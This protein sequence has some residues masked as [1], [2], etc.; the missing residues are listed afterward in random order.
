MDTNT[1]KPSIAVIM[2]TYN[3]EKYLREQ[4][5]SILNQ[6]DVNLDLYVRDDGSVDGTEEILNQY[7][8]RYPQVHVDL[9]ANAGV[10]NS[11]MNCL[12]SVPG[13]YQYY[14][15]A[16]QD[17]IWLQDKCIAGISALK[18]TGKALYSSNQECVDSDGKSRGLRYTRNDHIHLTTMGIVFRNTIAGCTFIFTNELAEK[19]RSNPFSSELLRVRI[20]DV[21][22]AA[23]ASMN[24]GIFYD[25][26]SHMEY[27]QHQ[28]NV[29]GV[30]EDTLKSDLRTKLS[31]AVNSEQRNGRSR[32]ASELVKLYPEQAQNDQLLM[33]CAD[34]KSISNRIRLI[35]RYGEVSGFTGERFSGFAGKVLFG[36]F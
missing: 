28:D 18:R 25:Q 11:F 17:D 33:L 3:G 32:L 9:A 24:G 31:K 14:G 34:Q 21:C 26:E 19:L 2:S 10:G 36:L 7:S 27:R 12:Y 29:V 16:D 23:A 13:E 6:K 5:D 35:R 20:H 1:T 22:V 8:K 30:K 15:F 4:L